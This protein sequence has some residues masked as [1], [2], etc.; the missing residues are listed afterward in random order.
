MD[1][2]VEKPRQT[3]DKSTIVQTA[4]DLLDE[5]GLD[6]LSTRRLAAKLGV[7]GPSLYWHF[8]NKDQLLAEMSG[9][10]FMKALPRPVFDEPNF[11]WEA[12]LIEGAYGIRNTALSRR[13]GAKLMSKARPAIADETREYE[14]MARCMHVHT[15]LGL[16]ESGMTLLTLGRFAMGW[17]LYEQTIGGREILGGGDTGFEFG[18]QTFLR[19]VRKRVAEARN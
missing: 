1:Q 19:G 12:W 11:D 18:L 7:K 17:A 16:P 9:V 13:D 14:E 4:L 2:A 3:L 6:G 8:R 10:L 15:G 5:V